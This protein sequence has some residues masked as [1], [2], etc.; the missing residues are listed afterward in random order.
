MEF[1]QHALSIF[2]LLLMGWFVISCLLA[3][4]GHFDSW[5]KRYKKKDRPDK[6]EQE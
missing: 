3:A 1:M 5:D 6:P 4:S 2:F